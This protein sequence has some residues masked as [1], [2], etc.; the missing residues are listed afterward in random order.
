MAITMEMVKELRERTNAGVLDCKKALTETDGDL[1]KAAKLL[2]EK[3]L[4]SAAK[5]SGRIAVEGLVHSYIHMGGKIG[6]LL[7]VNC[8]TDFV[9]KTEDFKEL[10]N[11][12]TLHIAAMNPQYV[13]REEVSADDLEREREILTAQARNEGKPEK[14]V[15]KMVTGRLEKFYQEKV[16]LE[17][18]YVKDDSLT[19]EELVAEK[20]A[21]IGENIK[22]RRFAR[23]ELG[24]GLEK[25][26]D[27]FV[28]EVLS[29]NK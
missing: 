20:I 4:A 23:Y 22:V 10:L 2:R 5:K 16:L 25:K 11:N 7:E 29:Y 27:N 26:K 28:E 14:I 9:A 13:S 12:L 18:P 17:Q 15:E 21:K 19:I 8:E 3:G 24:E 1:E 6:V